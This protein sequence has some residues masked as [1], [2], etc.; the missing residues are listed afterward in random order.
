MIS[1]NRHEARTAV[2]KA[3]RCLAAEG[4]V[5]GTAGNVS[6]A[7]DGP[8]APRWPSLPLGVVLADARPEDVSIIDLDA[9]HHEGDLTASSELPVHLG[10]LRERGG[11]AYPLH[12]GHGPLAGRR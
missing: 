6:L 10:L 5:I 2:A 9:G 8:T 1:I 3:S 11:D 4:L 7:F 12:R